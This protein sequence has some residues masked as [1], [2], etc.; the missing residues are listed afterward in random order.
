MRATHTAGGYTALDPTCPMFIRG[1]TVFIPTF[2]SWLGEA[3]DKK[4]PL[5][6]AMKVGAIARPA[7]TASET[8]L[9]EASPVTESSST[10]Q[11]T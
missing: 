6:R 4:T 1:D 8:V 5:L 10:L 9:L 2:V 11:F 7:S 3:L